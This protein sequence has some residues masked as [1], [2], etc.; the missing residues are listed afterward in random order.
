MPRCLDL[1]SYTKWVG[2]GWPYCSE[3]VLNSNIRWFQSLVLSYTD[4]LSFH[5]RDLTA[6]PHDFPPG[7]LDWDSIPIHDRFVDRQTDS[8]DCQL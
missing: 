2:K 5:Y 1:S 8:S 7:T 4:I 3:T 6:K